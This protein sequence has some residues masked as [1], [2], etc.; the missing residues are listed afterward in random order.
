G[1][2]W[3]HDTT[4][5][6]KK[7]EMELAGEMNLNFISAGMIRQEYSFIEGQYWMLTKDYLMGDFNLTKNA[8]TIGVY[9]H[10]TTSS[11]NFVV[12]QPHD[13][14]FYKSPVNVVVEE[15]AMQKDDAYWA[16][17]RHDSLT[18]RENGIYEMIDSIKRVPLFDTYMDLGYMLVNG[19][20]IWG[21]F[22]L[23]P[24]YKLLSF[25][26]IEGARFRFGG[27]TSNDFSTK[28]M[29]SGHLA[30]GTL[31]RRFKFGAGFLYMFNTKPRRAISGSYLYDMIQLGQSQDAFSQESFFAVFFRRNPANKLSMLER[32]ELS[33]EHEW[34]AGF[35]NTFHFSHRKL[36]PVGYNRFVVFPDDSTIMVEDNIISAE[37]GV[38]FR[39]AYKERYILGNFTRITI[40]TKYPIFELHYAYG[41]PGIFG[42]EYEYHRL[43]FQVKQWFNILS[44]GWSKYVLETGKIWGTLPYPLLKLQ[45]A[46]ETFLFD[47]FAYNLMDYYEFINDEYISLYYTHHFDGFFLNRIPLMRKLKWR[48]VIHGRILLGN[49]SEENRDYS[50]FPGRRLDMTTPYYEAGAGV[51]N[52]FKFIRV[53]AIWRLTYR[54]TNNPRNFGVFISAALTF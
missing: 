18:R 26:A 11:R 37:L 25:N 2:I 35:S 50:L 45:P 30:Y 44:I 24:Y 38:K 41:V 12:N 14:E 47:E 31:D 33:Y 13:D 10:R 39:W 6:V 15:N 5:A 17:A 51:E 27:Q 1:T 49:L 52:I 40:G 36:F 48:T 16:V 22:E 21:N 8:K 54:D 32:Y 3:I 19:Y 9:G 46:N 23:G 29:L 28:L 53:D 4:Y 20:Y 42:S 7:V 43:Q 34:V